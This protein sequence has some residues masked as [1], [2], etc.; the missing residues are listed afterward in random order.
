MRNVKPIPVFAVKNA[1]SHM[2]SLDNNDFS[3]SHIDFVYHWFDGPYS[4]ELTSKGKNYEIKLYERNIWDGNIGKSYKKAF[5]LASKILIDIE[6]S[7]CVSSKFYLDKK[8]TPH[9]FSLDA[10]AISEYQAFTVY[11]TLLLNSYFAKND[12]ATVYADLDTKTEGVLIYIEDDEVKHKRISSRERP[13]LLFFDSD[14]NQHKIRPY[15]DEIQVE[16]KFASLPLEKKEEIA[17]SGAVWAMKAMFEMYNNIDDPSEDDGK[18]TIYWCKKIADAGDA[19]ALYNMGAFHLRGLYVERDF[20]KAFSYMEKARDAGDEDAKDLYDVVKKLADLSEKA[21]NGD[22]NAMAD[23]GAILISNFAEEEVKLAGLD[24]ISK[25]SDLG[26]GRALWHMSNLYER[27][28]IVE[29]DVEKQLLLRKGG[30]LRGDLDCMLSVVLI[31]YCGRFEN[32][33]SIE[34][35]DA[36]E[37]LAKLKEAADKGDQY[38]RKLMGEVSIHVDKDHVKAVEW[39]EKALEL[40]E[41]N[42]ILKEL[43]QSKFRI[44]YDEY[45]KEIGGETLR[46]SIMK[47]NAKYDPTKM[48]T[49]NEG[50]D[51]STKDTNNAFAK[52][53]ADLEKRAKQ[54]DERAVKVLGD[55]LLCLSTNAPKPQNED[56]TL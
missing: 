33:Y 11:E 36:I 29:R 31:F 22:V 50:W 15:E 49:Y 35:N 40:G 38:A 39:F 27:G 9:M 54:G 28:V 10:E 42:E 24:I 20:K 52:C 47:A 5:L 48:R 14:L 7:E 16:K 4:V 25:A 45:M 51:E 8:P 30:A 44:S 26:S 17:N 12:F 6:T 19:T 55:Y 23:C 1:V 21:E 41:N 32:T 2:L 46:E 37:A 13:D 34:E 56:P 53:M 3:D 43:Q 18:K